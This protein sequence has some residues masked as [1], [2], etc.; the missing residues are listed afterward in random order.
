M[1]L[2]TRYSEL[3]GI[4]ITDANKARIQGAIQRCLAIFED[5]LG[6]TLDPEQRTFNEFESLSPTVAYRIFPLR[7]KDKYHHI[8]AATAVYD[9]RILRNGNV[10][11]AL[12][13]DEW[14]AVYRRGIYKFFTINKILNLP[15]FYNTF[16]YD[17][18]L[19]IINSQY[20]NYA[21]LVD[22]DWMF[23]EDAFPDDL[24]AVFCEMVTYYSDLKRNIRSET[25]GPHSFTKFSQDAPEEMESNRRIINRFAGPRGSIV[26][27]NTFNDDTVNI[28]W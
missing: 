22:A 8:D 25:L 14:S 5:L 1:D 11:Q 7:R 23:K 2:Q 3:T 17:T 28:Y 20:D 18:Y 6:Y 19:S 27:N 15:A 9:V 21:I 13:S 10:N 12:A 24:M 4:Q 26:R 16:F